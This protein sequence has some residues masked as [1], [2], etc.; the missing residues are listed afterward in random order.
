MT[1]GRFREFY[2]CDFDIAGQ[3]DAMIPDAECLKVV[4]EILNAL[5]LKS[6]VIKVNHR[7]ILDGM[8]KICGVPDGLF[9]PICSAIDKLDKATW[10]E[11]KNEMVNEKGLAEK[12]ADRIGEFVVL[13][14]TAELITKL[15]ADGSELAG[16]KSSKAGLES[17]KTLF[18]YCSKLG[19]E[20]NLKFD[21]SLARGLDYYTG[22]IYEAVLTEGDGE[23]GSIAAGGRYDTLVKLFS[24]NHKHSVPCVGVSIGIERI[25]AI[26]QKTANQIYPTQCYVTSV[27]K[28]LTFDQLALIDELWSADI[29]AEQNMKK[30]TPLLTQFQYCEEKSIP[31]VVLVGEDELKLGQIKLRVVST[32]KTRAKD[33][34]TVERKDLVAEVNKVLT[35]LAMANLSVN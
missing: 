31:L 22:V 7:E 10:A 16:N 25:F 17:L 23:V 8:F 35:E 34:R 13:N 5:D 27:G 18:E 12:A 14:G 20:Q 28:N 9:K 26:L 3:F 33:E 29:R 32:D 24:D 1:K 4:A 11:V 30:K 15:L 19:I 2:Q 6:F 21:L